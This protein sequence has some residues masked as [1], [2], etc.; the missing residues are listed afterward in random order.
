MVTTS[1]TSDDKLK[2][3]SQYDTRMTQHKEVLYKHKDR[4][5]FHSYMASSTSKQLTVFLVCSMKYIFI[6]TNTSLASS[7]IIL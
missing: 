7:Y 3:G 6:G 1:H 5:G 2:P 4:A